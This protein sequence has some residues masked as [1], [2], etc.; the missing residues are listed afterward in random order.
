MSRDDR[1]L[2]PPHPSHTSLT[3]PI[4]LPTNIVQ[5]VALTVNV[6]PQVSER[7]R[8]RSESRK[9]STSQSQQTRARTQRARDE[10][11]VLEAV[12]RQ[13]KMT[14]SLASNP[15]EVVPTVPSVVIG[16]GRGIQATLDSS[17]SSSSSARGASKESGGGQAATMPEDA[18]EGSSLFLTALVSESTPL[19]EAED[20]KSALMKK[21]SLSHN[22][23]GLGNCTNSNPHAGK[24]YSFHKRQSEREAR[25]ED[26]LRMERNSSF[27]FRQNSRP[28]ETLSHSMPV[29]PTG[30]FDFHAYMAMGPARMPKI[31]TAEVG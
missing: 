20:E 28:I 10:E 14:A 12:E 2:P 11:M 26:M 3:P 21:L 18:D 31:Q 19:P 6:A 24:H 8:S 27:D 17:S 30:D 23:R 13:G 5:T 1:P 7:V 4:T 29:R 15:S 22:M 25:Y 9:R 16:S